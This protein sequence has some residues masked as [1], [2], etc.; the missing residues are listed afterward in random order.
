MSSAKIFLA[1]AL[2]S[3]M[4]SAATTYVIHGR[5]EAARVTTVVER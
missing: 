1:I 3:A 5:T 4:V 2:I